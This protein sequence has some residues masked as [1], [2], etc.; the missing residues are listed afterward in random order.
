[1]NANAA[2]A[3]GKAVV[4]NLL[5]TAATRYADKEGLYC[6]GTGR[7]FTF[8]EQ[9]ARSN[10]LAHALM[11]LPLRRGE[12]VA[13][14]C[15]NRAEIVEIY[16]ALAKSGLVGLPLNY[17]LAPA[18]I[19]ALIEAMG[20]TTLLCEARFGGII[21]H[22]RQHAPRLVH[23]IWIGAEAPP[24]CLPYEPLLAS[25]PATEPDVEIDEADPFYFNLT[26]GTTGLPKAYLLTQYNSS[27]LGSSL[28]AFGT[29]PDD[30]ILT[31]FP[32]FGRVAFGWL[33]AGIVLGARSVLANFEPHSVLRLIE[34][35]S[36]TFTM[37][38]PTMAAMLLAVPDV[39]S[40]DLSSLRGV[41]FVG[42][43]LPAP[44]R[45]QTMARLCPRIYEGY[46]LQE[47]GWLAVSTPEDRAR[48][49]DS[50]GLPVLFA[51]YRIAD[52]AGRTLPAGEIG[53][54]VARSP[55]GVTEYFQS[56]AKTAETFR[57]GWFHTGDLGRVDADGYLYI[58]GRVKDMIISGGQNIHSAE[59]EAVLLTLPG[60]TD[61]AVIGLPDATWG[62]RVAAVIVPADSLTPDPKSVQDSCRQQLAGFKVPR[63]VFFQREA[64][65]RTPTGK[66]QKF[67]LVE[68]YGGPH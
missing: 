65:P 33:C 32:A 68:R 41:G 5:K 62:E 4:G 55:N 49:P 12:V 11:G 23:Y 61:C 44:I 6:A 17:R 16:F 18:E 2:R 29:R 3:L 13:F 25:A 1:M 37:L 34:E 57:G 27:T 66:V 63:Q 50:V 19:A 38:V 64:L 39:E 43:V 15:S 20:A 40:H 36:V 67:L 31:V 14:L 51:E 46:G 60:V 53:E 45:D 56:P 24:S 28:L 9:S 48:R 10:R 8:R 30:V 7:R 26:S 35:E 47:T 58:C 42:S 52:A 22:L 21:D 59:I 54:V